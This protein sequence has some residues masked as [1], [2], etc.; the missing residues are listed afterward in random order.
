MCTDICKQRKATNPLMN[1][2]GQCVYRNGRQKCSIK[3]VVLKNFAIFTRNFYLRAA[4]LKNICERLLLCLRNADLLQQ[5][6][7]LHTTSFGFF[8]I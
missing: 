8:I 5:M 1:E 2:Q 7:K 6:T 3:K 4:I